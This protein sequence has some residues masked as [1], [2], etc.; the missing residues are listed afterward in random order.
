[1]YSYKT[2]DNEQINHNFIIPQ[3]LVLKFSPFFNYV[4]YIVFKEYFQN[5]AIPKKT[6]NIYNEIINSISS[7]T[8][9]F[10]NR[11]N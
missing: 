7:F 4:L 6:M 9:I 1:M 3:T 11:I 8:F 10:I 5:E 2:K